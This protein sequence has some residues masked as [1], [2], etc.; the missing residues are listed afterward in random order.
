MTQDGQ[1]K[2]EVT[3]LFKKPSP[4]L[5]TSSHLEIQEEINQAEKQHI[6]NLQEKAKLTEIKALLEQDETDLVELRRQVLELIRQRVMK[7]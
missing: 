6:Q 3:D 5:K 7:L 1:N 4:T 2:P